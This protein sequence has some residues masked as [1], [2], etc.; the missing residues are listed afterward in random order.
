MAEK[1][2]AT[3]KR[4]STE[5]FA[6]VTAVGTEERDFFEVD[7]TNKDLHHEITVNSVTINFA[8]VFVVMKVD[9]VRMG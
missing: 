1:V 3:T 2:E 4:R 7:Y 9:G 8:R 6:V 5:G